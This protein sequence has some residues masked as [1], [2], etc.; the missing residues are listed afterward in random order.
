MKATDCFVFQSRRVVLCALILLALQMGGSSG[1]AEEE[2]RSSDVI[3]LKSGPPR[4]GRSVDRDGKVFRLSV[5]LIPGQPPAR[6]TFPEADVERIEFADDE[7][8]DAFL[9]GEKDQDIIAAAR[10]W[11]ANEKFTGVA[12]SPAAAIGRRYA[13]L[14][15]AHEN[16]LFHQRALDIYMRLEK[17]AW[18]PSERALGRQGRLRAMIATG[19]AGEAVE[20]AVSLAES[21]EDPAVLIEAKYILA[22]AEESRLRQLLED[23]PRWEED[24]FVRPERHR[25]Y[26]AALD[27]FLYPALFYGSE[28]EAASRGLWAAC[29]IYQL[30]GDTLNAR[31]TAEDIV[32]L[33]PGTPEAHS[34]QDFLAQ[35]PGPATPPDETL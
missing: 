19:R 33:Y 30:G 15:L 14:L 13:D 1:L 4:A 18:S 9:R 5:P 34:A 32:V 21:S 35:D 16:P 7:D 10:W 31:A 2:T 24:I 26:H 28:I 22:T 29:R 27:L 23:H 6:V 11:G 25:L 3:F 12:N 17:D 20:E 8:R